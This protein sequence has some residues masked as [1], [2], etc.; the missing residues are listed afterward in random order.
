MLL[1]SRSERRRTILICSCYRILSL[2]DQR[3]EVEEK[4]TPQVEIRRALAVTLR[5]LLDMTLNGNT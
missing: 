1:N 5:N 3:E 4:N 2:R